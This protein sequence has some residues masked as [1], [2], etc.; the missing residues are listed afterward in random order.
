MRS[1]RIGDMGGEIE[2][3][4][5]QISILVSRSECLQTIFTDDKSKRKPVPKIRSLFKGSCPSTLR[6]WC[7][8]VEH[9]LFGDIFL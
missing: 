6:T 1:G 7:P 8:T 4:G 3:A 9:I 2:T 5:I